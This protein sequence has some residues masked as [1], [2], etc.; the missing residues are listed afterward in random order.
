M[1]RHWKRIMEETGKSV[2]ELNLKTMTLSKVFDL[3][4]QNYEEKVQEI[5]QEAKDEAKNEEN[6]Q[7]IESKW[8]AA[9]FEMI[10]YGKTT[11]DDKRVYVLKGV[12]EIRELLDDSILVLQTLQASRYIR[13]IKDRVN[14]WEKD[15]NTI[16]DTID[17]WMIVQRKW[18]YLEMI[19]GNDDI[20]QQLPEEA[21]KFG[22]TDQRFKSI[23]DVTQSN[24]V[25]LYAC[26]KANGGDT[27]DML[28]GISADL[29]RCQKSLSQYLEGKQ[30]AFPRFY[31]I[32]Q[33]DL[34]QILGSSD[35]KAIQPYL[36]SL[37]D[38]CK[39]LN[40]GKGDKQFIGMTSEEGENY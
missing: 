25:V 40:F 8:K 19:F 20:K 16:M 27:L 11:N 2:V 35:P 30:M 31:F 26:T 32:S 22:K 24:P 39:R 3:E 9:T 29:D 18:M 21:K 13:A 34:L 28:R 15:L 7:S 23:M 5:C 36:I 37:F 4:L 17:T 12:D 14:R 10:A 38:N 6:I 1:E 33:D